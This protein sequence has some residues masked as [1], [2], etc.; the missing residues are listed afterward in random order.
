MR[1]LQQQRIEL[2]NQRL[3][4]H[5]VNKSLRKA[6][7]ICDLDL[8]SCDEAYEKAFHYAEK[9]C[10]MYRDY[11]FC[12]K[13][14]E[15]TLAKIQPEPKV[16]PKSAAVPENGLGVIAVLLFLLAVISRQI[17]NT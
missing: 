10:N 4:R 8:Q 1:K 14:V 3:I 11:N 2:Y 6:D 7:R 16:Q 12:E 5:H 13:V 17:R 15:T 9:Y